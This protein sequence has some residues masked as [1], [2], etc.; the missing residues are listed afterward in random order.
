MNPLED[1]LVVV[2]ATGTLTGV[3]W[4]VDGANKTGAG[5][6]DVVVD[7]TPYRAE[8]GRERPDVGKHFH[9]AAYNDSGFIFYLPVSKLSPGA[10]KLAIRVISHDGKSYSEGTPVRLEIR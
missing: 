1:Q 2:P 10:H 7:G 9:I 5:G 8:S 6:V 3:G 4:A